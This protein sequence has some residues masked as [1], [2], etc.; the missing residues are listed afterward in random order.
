[1]RVL[2]GKSYRITSYQGQRGNEY[3]TGVDFA[4][5]LYTPLYAPEAG[6]AE[7]LT[8]QY[9]GKFIRLYGSSGRWHFVHLHSFVI[10][11]GDTVKKGQ[12]IGVTGNTG[13]ST[14][15]HTHVDLYRD[16]QWLDVLKILENL[17]MDKS[18]PNEKAFIKKVKKD[19]VDWEAIENIGYADWWESNGFNELLHTI[20]PYV[21]NDQAPYG[22]QDVIDAVIY[23]GRNLA[24]WYTKQDE[25]EP[26]GIFRAPLL[27]SEYKESLREIE[28]LKRTIRELEKQ[29]DTEEY[30]T[31]RVVRDDLIVSDKK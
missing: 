10:E 27:T 28:N 8:D 15:P 26:T 20:L 11:H 6:K 25:Y 13:K 4:T 9:G 12:L 17:D 2:F 14:G 22:R 7:T 29:K 31:L 5:P 18:I 16:Y 30:V 21:I 24:D 23:K 1:M 3:H 19:R